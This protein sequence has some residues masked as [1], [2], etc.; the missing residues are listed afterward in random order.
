[1]KTD[2]NG[3]VIDLEDYQGKITTIAYKY[4]TSNDVGNDLSLEFDDIHQE[5]LISF[6][7]AVDRYDSSKGSFPSFFELVADNHM[8][9]MLRDIKARYTGCYDVPIEDAVFE[10]APD[11]I[12][13][14]EREE[15]IKSAVF[16]SLSERDGSIL[17]EYFGVG[18]LGD[19]G[20][21]QQ[22]LAAKY[23]MSQRGVSGILKKTVANTELKAILQSSFT[24]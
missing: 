15:A 9:D 6:F 17:L 16:S 19:K 24:S 8:K 12:D 3:K 11:T 2:N 23:K 14:L 21:N 7:D 10:L 5:V 13:S 4:A 22:E 20:L 1:M 18:V